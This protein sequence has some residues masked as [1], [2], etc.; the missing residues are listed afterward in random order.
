[1][2]CNGEYNCLGNYKEKNEAK[3]LILSEEYEKKEKMLKILGIS[4][5]EIVEIVNNDA[6]VKE[7]VN[8]AV[9]K[10]MEEILEKRD[11]LNEEVYCEIARSGARLLHLVK[12]G[13]FMKLLVKTRPY[14][15]Y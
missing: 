2:G 1:M 10:A 7:A 6:I 14:L 5:D 3:D 13:D 4:V 8:F 11:V 15:K 12:T 9:Y